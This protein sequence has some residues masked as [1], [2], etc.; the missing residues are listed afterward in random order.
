M[1]ANALKAEGLCFLRYIKKCS[2]VA[3]EV[4]RFNCDAIGL[5]ANY[6]IEIETKISIAD[7]R[8][9]FRKHKHMIYQSG[10]AGLW[11]PNYFYIMI[12]LELR[13]K[14]LAVLDEKA[15]PKYGLI[16]YDPSKNGLDGRKNEVARRA[17]KLHEGKP[18]E[19]LKDLVVAR[20]SSELCG[21]H[22]YLERVSTDLSNLIHSGHR[23]ILQT[24]DGVLKA[25]AE[26]DPEEARDV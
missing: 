17:Q 13:D 6:S 25:P 8:N 23:G 10:V 18:R 3:T 7:L 26:E 9:D 4:G 11:V 14:A 19:R 2:L 24:I 20:M 21:L 22:L 12:P 15:S 5:C 1:N 16:C